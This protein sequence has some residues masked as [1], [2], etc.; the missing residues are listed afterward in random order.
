MTFEILLVSPAMERIVLPFQRN[1]AVG[2]PPR[3]SH[4]QLPDINRYRAFDFDMIINV[5]RT[6]SPGNEQRSSGAVQPRTCL[7]A[8]IL[9][10]YAIRW[11]MSW[12]NS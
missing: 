9:P 5:R 11:W 6:D 7:V 1:P 2:S 10:G 3:P 4:R 12:W 8:A